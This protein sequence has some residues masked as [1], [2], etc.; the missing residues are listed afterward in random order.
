MLASVNS[1][2]SF[3]VLPSAPMILPFMRL[4]SD[5]DRPKITRK[6]IISKISSSFRIKRKATSGEK[7]LPMA[8]TTS[9]AFK[10]NEGSV[11]FGESVM[12]MLPSFST[13]ILA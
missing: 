4:M 8:V 2:I 9:F 10:I 13:S 3:R 5:S 12:A 7:P 11:A 6:S 1:S